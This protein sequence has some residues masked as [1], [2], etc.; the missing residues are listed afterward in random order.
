MR[1][2]D[3]API[4][5]SI[6][7]VGG[8]IGLVSELGRRQISKLTMNRDKLHWLDSSVPISYL[9]GR[10]VDEVSELVDAVTQG[11]SGW[12]VWGEAADVA[13]FAAFVADKQ[14]HEAGSD[15]AVS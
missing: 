6:S 4:G 13:N 5:R 7:V 1:L 10:L 9:I 15:G 12:D 3:D 14:S 11:L 2:E 8:E